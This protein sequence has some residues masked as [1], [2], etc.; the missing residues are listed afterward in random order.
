[1]GFETSKFGNGV[2]TGSGGNVVTTKGTPHNYF[3][4][5]DTGG[6]DGVLKVEGLTEELIINLSGLEYNDSIR[7]SLVPYVIPAGAVIKAVYVNVEE[8]FDLGGTNPVLD[9]G[10]SGSEATNGFTVD[11]SVLEATG[12]SNQTANLSGTW[13][14]EAP[15]A[16]DTTVAAVFSADANLTVADVGKARITIVYDR[17]ALGL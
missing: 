5:R 15:L 8:A 10:T 13:D 1:M 6:T 7:P 2:S 16:A 14:S 4:S 11:D 3:G 17:A 12:P 9:I